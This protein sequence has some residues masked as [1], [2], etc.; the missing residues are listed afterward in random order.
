[1]HT[2]LNYPFLT[3]REIRASPPN[4]TPFSLP[5][6]WRRVR[7]KRDVLQETRFIAQ[8]TAVPCRATMGALHDLRLDWRALCSL[9]VTSSE[10]SEWGERHGRQSDEGRSE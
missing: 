10:W 6:I 8:Q 9:A 1:M 4:A 2:E 7:E 3:V 5:D